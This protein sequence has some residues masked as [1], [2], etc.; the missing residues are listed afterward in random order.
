ML[1][2]NPEKQN[3]HAFYNYFFKDKEQIIVTGKNLF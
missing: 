3:C 1:L 2:K